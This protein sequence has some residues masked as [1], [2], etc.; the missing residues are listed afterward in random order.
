VT[1]VGSTPDNDPKGWQ[2]K[3]RNAWA[4]AKATGD[5]SGVR[6]FGFAKDVKNVPIIQADGDPLP[7]KAY[8]STT[9]VSVPDGPEGTQRRYVNANEIAYIVLS[10]KFTSAF[11]VLPG[12][13][14]VVYRPKTDKFVLGVYGDGGKLGEASVR[15]HQDL[16]NNPLIDRGGVM[17]AKRGLDD[18]TLTVVFPGQGTTRTVDAAK[19]RAEIA[20]KGRKALDAWG[21]LERLKACAK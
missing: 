5:Y 4:L 13:L 1:A 3:C 21:G 11:K 19:W 8:I 20:E 10:K 18:D 2:K 14:A 16:G 17:R 7:G 6:I 9:S 12:D 15:L